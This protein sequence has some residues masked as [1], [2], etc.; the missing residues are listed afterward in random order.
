MHDPARPLVI[1]ECACAFPCRFCCH[2]M[3]LTRQ[4]WGR[5]GHIC[6]MACERLLARIKAAAPGRAPNLE[7]IVAAGGLTQW[8][9]EYKKVRRQPPEGHDTC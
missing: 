1:L 2:V 3:L 6:N 9:E 5:H 7:R 8:L 4:V